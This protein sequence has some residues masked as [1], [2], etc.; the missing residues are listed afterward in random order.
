MKKG[1]VIIVTNA[2]AKKQSM[3]RKRQNAYD[4]SKKELIKAIE[5]NYDTCVNPNITIIMEDDGYAFDYVCRRLWRVAQRLQRSS[6]DG[7]S[8]ALHRYG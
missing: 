1:E 4:N 6:D 5:S 2:D 3:Q 7:W 8:R